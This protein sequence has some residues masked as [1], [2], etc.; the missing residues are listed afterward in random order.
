MYPITLSQK[1]I[2]KGH[3][4][5]L[6][7]HPEGNLLKKAIQVGIPTIPV[8]IHKY[9]D[10]LA[11]WTLA[12]IIRREKTQIIHVHFATDLWIIVPAA[13]LSKINPKVILTRHMKSH[14]RKKD[15]LHRLIYNYVSKVIA[16]SELVK[17]CL[18]ESHPLSEDKIPIIYYGLDLVKYDY[19][20]YDGKGIKKEFNIAPRTKVVGIVGRL[21]PGK[22]QDEFL[23]A[24]KLIINA[25]PEVIF[26]MVGEDIGAKGYK[27]YLVSLSKELGLEE[28]VIFTGHRD[29][30]PEIMAAMDVFVLTSKAEAFG[31]V[32]IEAMALAKP[33]VGYRS[34]AIEEIVKDGVSGILV[35]FGEINTL[36]E[37]VISLLIDQDRA[38]KMGRQGRRLVE[39]RFDLD[40]AISQTIKL[41]EEVLGDEG[42]S[43]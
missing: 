34:G 2:E 26:L 18:L 5:K 37:A 10:I 42:F 1:L 21:N 38:D 8:N 32:L 12:G 30:I 20:R 11:I 16:I 33:I 43:H 17:E 35:P 3:N 36:S 13:I 4:L 19:T 7:A 23:Q 29:D 28:K 39:E 6:I 9:I 22:G 41:Y 25:E 27:D 15:I 14:R 31:L 40:L 24:A